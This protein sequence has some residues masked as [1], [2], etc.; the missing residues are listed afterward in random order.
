VD[1]VQAS[2]RGALADGGRGQAKPR[3]LIEAEDGVLSRSEGRDPG[4]E[5]S[6]TDR[7]LGA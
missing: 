1:A 2:E 3:Q 5:G 7:R 6:G 4:I